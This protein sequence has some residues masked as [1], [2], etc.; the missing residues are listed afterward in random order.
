MSIRILHD[1]V[2]P[3]Q[4]QS[5][6]SGLPPHPENAADSRMFGWSGNR[7]IVDK[8][9]P[10]RLSHAGAWTWEWGTP[11]DLAAHIGNGHPWMPARLDPGARRWQSNS[12]YAEVLSL[13][14]DNGLSIA[15]CLAIGFVQQHLT[16]GIESASSC[17][18]SEKNPDGHEKFRLVFALAAPLTGHANIRLCNEYL[19]RV[20]GHADPSAKDASRYYFGASGRTAFHLTENTLPIDFLEQAIAWGTERDRQIEAEEERNAARWSKERES[21]S[22]DNRLQQV[23]EALDCIPPYSPGHNTYGKYVRICGAVLRELGAD[24]RALLMGAPLARGQDIGGF[25]KFLRSVERSR[26]AGR[27]ATLGSLFHW[28][29]EHGYRF[30][31]KKQGPP[32]SIGSGRKAL[33][34][35][36]TFGQAPAPLRTVKGEPDFGTPGSGFGGQGSRE[37]SDKAKRD[38]Q[39]AKRKFQEQQ[40]WPELKHDYQLT[41]EGLGAS[42]AAITR[43]QGY[44]PA[45]P[46]LV[47]TVAIQGG[48][49]SGKTEAI[50]RA[51]SPDWGIVWIAPRN[52]LLRGTATRLE[53]RG[54]TAYHYQ[55]DVQLHRHMLR[56]H[57]QGVMMLAPDSLKGYSTGDHAGQAIDWARTLVVI[58]EFASV[59]SEVLGKSASLLEF[60]RLITTAGGLVVADAF[61]SDTDLQILQGY[62]PESPLTVLIQDSIPAPKTITLLDC[63]TAKGLI[64]MKSEGIPLAQI[65]EWIEQGIRQ[66][67]IATDNK[68]AALILRDFVRRKGLNVA[69]TC[70][71][72]VEANQRLLPNPDR[73]YQKNV[74]EVAIITPTLE[75]GGDIQTPFERG[76]LLYSGVVSPKSAM[77]LMGRFRQVNTWSIVA[78]RISHKAP[79]IKS[80]DSATARASS[81]GF[82]AL[83]VDE[84]PLPN[85]IRD[86]WAARQ[87]AVKEIEST[88]GR[89]ILERQLQA[90]FAQVEHRVISL[91]KTA[92]PENGDA[93]ESWVSEWRARS[94]AVKVRRLT[95]L[96][97][98][99][100]QA[101][102][103]GQE[104]I[105]GKKTPKTDRDQRAIELT[106]LHSKYP[107]YVDK[108]LEGFDGKFATE[109][110]EKLALVFY[111]S[112]PDRLR[113]WVS[114]TDF[115]DREMQALEAKLPSHPATNRTSTHF[116]KYR[117]L[118]L[119]HDLDLVGVLVKGSRTAKQIKPDQT[120]FQANSPTVVKLWQQFEHQ[121][122]WRF[123]FPEVE[124]R[125]GFW[126][127]C[128]KALSWLGFQTGECGNASVEVPR[129]V[130]NGFT[131]RG[132]QR[133]SSVMSCHHTCWIEH[134]ESGSEFFRDTAWSQ[135]HQDLITHVSRSLAREE[136]GLQSPPHP[137]LLATAA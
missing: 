82:T 30:P 93:G 65:N 20:V 11:S 40:H 4:S 64:S 96:F 125:S 36:P 120:H 78:D 80:I 97:K 56:T 33:T 112:R 38:R 23:K 100:P 79:T 53:A 107:R 109:D 119:A 110:A 29:K 63:E 115:Y 22:L 57:Q 131:R 26:P 15:G 114:L 73:F 18:V 81:I 137:H 35:D 71:E 69:V 102:A 46:Q 43:Y 121:D 111:S 17:V 136:L 106:E 87:G 39:I 88:Y 105:R 67:A 48:L 124:T 49:G 126:A 10:D 117:Y 50:I 76:L 41:D 24:G 104:L 61:L 5:E 75:S 2:Q 77:Q 60:E 8:T 99:G 135:L 134:A 92:D 54:L 31:S 55:D 74:V 86:R 72:T 127:L 84:P 113:N 129:P 32:P 85:S 95:E 94:K 58:D 25:D 83:L 28:A 128:K 59:R 62:R 130:K 122:D 116:Q 21:M 103:H 47:G 42:G 98:G 91:K 45:L 19:A 118:R 14:I 52:G 132:E 108:V 9:N 90:N 12:N 66:I 101:L 3:P 37:L 44:C 13:D 133:Y 1:Q 123:L 7:K 70:S 16:I 34:L 89:E 68:N 6:Y 27:A 51:L